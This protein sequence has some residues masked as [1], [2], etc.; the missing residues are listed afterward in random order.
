LLGKIIYPN[1]INGRLTNQYIP[2]SGLSSGM[3]LIT[4]T[5][6]KEIVYT[7]KIIKQD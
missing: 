5:K 6:N 2:L 7:S 4:F 3:Y 1:F